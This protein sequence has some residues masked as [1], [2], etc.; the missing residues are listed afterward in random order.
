MTQVS[1]IIHGWLGWCPNAR[2]LTVR[3]IP[4]LQHETA[5]GIPVQGAGLSAADGWLNR[6][7]RQMLFWAVMYTFAFSC[8]VPLFLT[9]GLARL[10]LSL[11]IF[12]GLGFSALFGRWLWDRF[13]KLANGDT[14]KPGPEVNVI[15]AI[16]IGISPLSVILLFLGLISSIP[17]EA[18]MLLPAFT[19]GFGLLVPW[20][21]LLLILLWERRTGHI[22]IFDKKTFLVTATRCSGNAHH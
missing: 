16:L 14:V 6:Y 21:F 13:G 1:E 5:G 12:G 4:V 8:F 11:G 15:V 18:A 20:C 9:T 17:F 19:M 22:L 2:T 3:E 7:R 10:I